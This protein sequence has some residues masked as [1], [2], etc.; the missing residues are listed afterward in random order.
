MHGN[1]SEWCWDWY[2][3]EYDDDD[4]TNPT[5]PDTGTD[6]VIRGG[7][8]HS[9]GKDIRS[10]F[11]DCKGPGARSGVTGFRVIRYSS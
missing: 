3:E 9:D 4:A 7:S 2:A 6:R 5:G 8:W 11:Q 1:V 10:A